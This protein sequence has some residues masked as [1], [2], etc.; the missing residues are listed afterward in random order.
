MTT[1][2][3]YVKSAQMWCKTTIAGTKDKGANKLKWFKQHLCRHK[4]KKVHQ[5][6][7]WYTYCECEKCGKCW[8]WLT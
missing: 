1:K 3:K 5:T 6:D 7:N 8:E 2:I 4:W